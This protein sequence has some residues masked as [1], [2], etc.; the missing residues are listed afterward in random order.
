MGGGG[1]AIKGT[2]KMISV[3]EMGNLTE[4]K[5]EEQSSLLL[6]NKDKLDNFRS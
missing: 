2:S 1:G 3:W 6:E 5:I 4:M